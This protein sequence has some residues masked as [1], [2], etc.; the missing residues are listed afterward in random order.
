MTWPYL[1][2]KTSISPTGRLPPL[3]PAH[4][5]PVDDDRYNDPPIASNY[6]N[7]AKVV[8]PYREQLTYYDKPVRRYP[9]YEDIVRESKPRTRYTSQSV[10]PVSREKPKDPKR[11]SQ[12][13]TGKRDTEQMNREQ[14]AP[15]VN[16]RYNRI[17]PRLEENYN[18]SPRPRRSK[19][20]PATSTRTSS[21]DEFP[22][23]RDPYADYYRPPGTTGRRRDDPRVL[24]SVLISDDGGRT[25]LGQSGIRNR[26]V[27]KHYPTSSPSIDN[28]DVK[29][30]IPTDRRDVYSQDTDS[31]DSN[32]SVTQL[33]NIKDATRKPNGNVGF[34]VDLSTD[35]AR[36]RQG[37]RYK[38][39]VVGK[40]RQ[41]LLPKLNEDDESFNSVSTN[42][43]R[44]VITTVHRIP[45]P[46]SQ[47]IIYDENVIPESPRSGRGSRRTVIDNDEPIFG[48]VS[49]KKSHFSIQEMHV[50][51][52]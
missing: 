31:I 49:S 36:S 17:L 6:N 47:R 11:G 4:P 8:K 30:I 2:K 25:G 12:R 26:R 9:S 29:A 3:K 10:P 20:K 16:D 44:D 52:H 1:K 51:C 28:R 21:L 38:R 39:D 15:F 14:E 48:E 41:P 43:D 19:E 42:S 24:E 27:V 35:E 45:S 34:T 46:K 22:V 18:L 13:S 50:F 32:N 40:K 7:N 33:P 5:Y 37:Y 23:N